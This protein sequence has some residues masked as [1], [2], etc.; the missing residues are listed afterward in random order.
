MQALAQAPPARRSRAIAAKIITN[1]NGHTDGSAN[2]GSSRRNHSSSYVSPGRGSDG[3]GRWGAINSYGGGVA[4]Q[5]QRQ[6]SSGLSMRG[7]P[8]RLASRVPAMGSATKLWMP[9][10]TRSRLAG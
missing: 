5:R 1:S 8:L 6:R 3:R 7:C 4:K 2:D 9:G 10:P